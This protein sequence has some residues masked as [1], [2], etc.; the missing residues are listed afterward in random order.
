MGE[1]M[2][3]IPIALSCGHL[4][5]GPAMFEMRPGQETLIECP[6]GCGMVRFVIEK[7][8]IAFGH[9]ESSQDN[10]EWTEE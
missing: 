10:I 6:E 5:Q 9:I 4:L 3:F 7:G 2:E 1:L 8:D